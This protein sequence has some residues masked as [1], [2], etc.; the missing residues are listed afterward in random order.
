MVLGPWH[1]IWEAFLYYLSNEAADYDRDVNDGQ[2][3]PAWMQIGSPGIYKITV[4]FARSES[5]IQ[6]KAG[7]WSQGF[8]ANPNYD[9]VFEAAWT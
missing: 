4:G 9:D 8:D 6:F 1:E 3:W 2:F 7:Q 5:Q